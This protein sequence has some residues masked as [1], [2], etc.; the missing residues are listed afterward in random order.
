MDGIAELGIAARL[1][2][3]KE[4]AVIRT[5][6]GGG[7]GGVATKKLQCDQNRDKR[8]LVVLFH[9]STNLGVVDVN[10]VVF[11]VFLA[12]T[13]LHSNRI[14]NSGIPIGG[15]EVIAVEIVADVKRKSSKWVGFFDYVVTMNKIGWCKSI[16]H[17]AQ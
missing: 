2:S 5:S 10:E 4:V 14:V 1:Q 9:T 13:K 15:V 8:V 17:Q 7:D 6:Q 16:Y 11:R 3:A 12:R